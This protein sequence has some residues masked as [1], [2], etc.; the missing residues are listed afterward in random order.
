MKNRNRS[1]TTRRWALLVAAPVGVTG[2]VAALPEAGGAAA[3]APREKVVTD[4]SGWRPPAGVTT[5]TV[6]LWGPGGSAGGGGGGG[7]AGPLVTKN[8]PTRGKGGGGAGG[9]G[10]GG[11]YV[12]CK[13]T[14]DPS[15]TYRAAA[16]TPGP[17]GRP[18][19]EGAGGGLGFYG[20][21][22]QAGTDA[23]RAKNV[24]Y[25]ME[26]GGSRHL[27][28]AEGGEP[29]HGGRP[30]QGGQN[31]DRGNSGHGGQGG[32]PGGP[33]PQSRQGK[34]LEGTRVDGAQGHA[35][36]GG[37]K[38]GDGGA[39]RFKDTDAHTV[40][41]TGGKLNLTPAE[42]TEPSDARI[43]IT[44]PAPGKTKRPDGGPLPKG[45]G[46]GGTAGYGG[47]G[48]LGGTDDARD[49]REGAPG[50]RGDAEARATSS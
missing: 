6:Y 3:P 8:V 19:A 28:E 21:T 32:L 38:G 31:G 29:G 16:G 45:V 49:G 22:G 43:D 36:W 5:A 14:V 46:Y 44:G 26:S 15:K 1:D 11:P 33:S 2:P 37:G 42:R 27:A 41:G 23:G 25:F 50:G 40:P 10:S 30:G 13:L 47:R 18:G 17:A 34:C 9:Q 48:G 24:T 4:V 39:T 12:V 7:G 20:R 35:G